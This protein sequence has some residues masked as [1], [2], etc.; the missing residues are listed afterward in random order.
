MSSHEITFSVIV[1]TY[2]RPAHLRN[3]LDCLCLNSF[4]NFEVV[5][6]DQSEIPTNV[7]E[8]KNKLNLNYHHV[9]FR[10]A[11]LARN[12][13]AKQAVGKILAFIDD[14]CIPSRRWLEEAYICFQDKDI[15]GLEGRISPGKYKN[16]RKNYRIVSNIGREGLAFMTANLFVFRDHFIRI[17]GFDERF[18]NPHFRE[19]TDLGWRLQDLGNVMFSDKVKVIHPIEIINSNQNRVH[20]FVHDPLL[21]KKK[22]EKYIELFLIERHYIHTCGFWDY[23]L[24]G[25]E[26]HGIDYNLI[27]KLLSCRSLN[28]GYVPLHKLLPLIDSSNNLASASKQQL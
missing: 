8:Y 22:P 11:A 12:Y 25:F 5:V 15:V 2:G 23:F 27:K 26:R 4:R 7:T 18:N 21:F 28:L 14:D 1:P 24:K 20:F 13:G 19:D 17:N 16:N 6:I 9:S 3:L 10:G